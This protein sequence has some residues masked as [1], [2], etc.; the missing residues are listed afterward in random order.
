MFDLNAYREEWLRNPRGDLLAGLVVALALIP[1]AIAFSIIAGV[2]PKVGLYASFSIAVLTAICGGRPGMISAATA[3]TAVLMVTLVRDHGLEYLLAATVLAGVLQI[4]AGYARLGNLMRFV[5]RSVMTGF[6]NALAILIFMA[7]LPELIGVPYLTY[8][9]VAA[10]LGI[11]YL[12]PYVTKAIPSP[13]VCILV[14]T[15]VSLGF[16]LD[17]RTVSDMG[18]LPDSFPVF[19]LP[20]IPLTLETLQI[21]LPYSAA[22]AAVG[23]L[24]SLM[25][26]SLVDELTDTPSDKNKECVGQGIANLC[27]GFIGGMAGCAMIGQSMINVKSGGRGRLSCFFAGVFLLFMIV[28]LGDWVGRIPMAALVAIMIMV[29][30]GTF[31]WSSLKQLKTH[32]R[33]SSIVMLATVICVVWTHNL[34]IGVLVGVLLSG[35]FFAAKISQIFGVRSELSADGRHRTYVVEGQVFFASADV[36]SKAFDFREALDRVTIDVSRAHIWDI[37]SVAALDMVVLKFRREGAE[38]DILGL[39]E[40]SETIVDKLAMHDKPGA[41]DA[42]GGH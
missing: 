23:L 3:A 15:T 25:T 40:A 42:L 26:A 30:I 1:E 20:D 21:I 8:V 13:L 4:G 9:M 12:F 10:G 36:F 19:L 11:I 31:S 34:A 14:L 5:S 17:I 29:S 27:T 7:Q 35:I 24:E 18:E 22:V 38:V 39:N 41:M 32:P 16:G 28:V 6:V 37:S 33:S 2:D